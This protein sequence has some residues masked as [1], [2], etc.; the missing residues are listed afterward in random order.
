MFVFASG[1]STVENIT[2]SAFNDTLTG[3]A[4]NNTIMGAAGADIMDTVDTPNNKA[5]VVAII[6]VHRDRCKTP[7]SG[8]SLE[9]STSFRRRKRILTRNWPTR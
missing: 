4:Q 9:Y 6:L 1:L 8:I 2:G 5:N 7:Q 3:D